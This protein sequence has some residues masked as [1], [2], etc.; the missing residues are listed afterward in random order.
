MVF[1]E[2]EFREFIFWFIKNRPR[3]TTFKKRVEN[4]S[5]DEIE[6]LKFSAKQYFDVFIEDISQYQKGFIRGNGSFSDYVPKD[7]Y[8]RGK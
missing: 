6:Q 7:T 5:E 1:I 4:F 8:K 2:K 3:G